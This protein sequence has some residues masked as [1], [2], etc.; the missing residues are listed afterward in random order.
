VPE[1]ETLPDC[2]GILSKLTEV[3]LVALPSLQPLSSLSST[4]RPLTI[5]GSERGP[6]PNDLC[7]LTALQSLSISDCRR[8]VVLPHGFGSLTALQTLN[9]SWCT[10]LTA[11]P[12]D[13]SSLPALQRLNISYCSRLFLVQTV[14]EGP[15][16]I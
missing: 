11:L 10:S 16:I 7:K 2:E 5:S 8:L 9:I 13:F 12:E 6:F 3:S 15:V 14:Y 1:L 4:V